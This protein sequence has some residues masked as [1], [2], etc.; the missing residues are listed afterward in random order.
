MNNLSWLLYWADVLPKL[1]NTFSALVPIGSG[2][3]VMWLIFL[4]VS[5]AADWDVENETWHQTWK[6]ARKKAAFVPWIAGFAAVIGILV[7]PFLP[8][9]DTIY[10]IAASE[11]AE[12]IVFSERVQNTTNKAFQAVDAW[13]DKQI[14]KGKDE[15]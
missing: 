9:K 7:P 5:Y 11:V 8:S 6:T 10:A 12:E 1:G 4:G 2:L 14:E 3:I 15:Q 13:L